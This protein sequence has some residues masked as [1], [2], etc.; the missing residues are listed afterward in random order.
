MKSLVACFDWRVD[1]WVCSGGQTWWAGWLVCIFKLRGKLRVWVRRCKDEEV[2]QSRLVCPKEGWWVTDV[3]YAQTLA[4]FGYLRY[5]CIGHSRCPVHKWLVQTLTCWHIGEKARRLLSCTA[6]ESFLFTSTPTII[7]R[8]RDHNLL[9]LVSSN[10][11]L[12]FNMAFQM[13]TRS[14]RLMIII[15][16]S[17]SFF[18]AE[19]SSRRSFKDHKRFVTSTNRMAYK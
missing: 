3:T 9:H 8:K 15:V 18:V 6:Q 13:L 19:L 11:T 17:F 10:A 4:A 2:E 5:R 1:R 16:I 7:I 14:Q 12:S